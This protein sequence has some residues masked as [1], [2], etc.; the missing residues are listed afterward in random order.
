HVRLLALRNGIEIPA[1]F[2]QLLQKM[3]AVVKALS[4]NGVA[5]SFGDD[6]GGRVFN[7]RRNRAEH[8]LDPLALG[9][10]L[11]AG[12]D[13][14]SLSTLTEE[15]IWL[16]GAQ[17]TAQFRPPPS[18]KTSPGSESFPDGGI[19]ISA[20][21]GNSREQMTIS[22]GFEKTG[23]NGHHH[24]DALSIRLSFQGHP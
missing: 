16:F 21:S 5:D 20:N 13:L 17:A 7:P 10:P 9:A 14:H 24:A 3:L 22:A 18:V 23:R 6:D 2:D 8:M 12:V 4:Q 11:F 19:Y 15:S 1:S